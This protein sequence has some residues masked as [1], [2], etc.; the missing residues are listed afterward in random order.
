MYKTSP[1]LFLLYTPI[2]QLFSI[3]STEFEHLI[4]PW[5]YRSHSLNSLPS[6]KRPSLCGQSI[7]PKGTCVRDTPIH[8]LTSMV[9]NYFERR[10][11]QNFQHLAPVC[12]PAPSG[13]S[14]P[15]HCSSARTLTFQSMPGL[16]PPWGH[17]LS[18]VVS[19][20]SWVVLVLLPFRLQDRHISREAFPVSVSCPYYY[21]FSCNNC[22]F[23]SKHLS[24]IMHPGRK[25]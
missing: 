18:A 2:H 25:L 14:P 13:I 21:A 15:L 9:R 12:S 3:P 11:K 4:S 19:S 23:P 10:T 8:I 16:H 6:P 20:N 7:Y 1:D 5:G 22:S 17:L 24:V